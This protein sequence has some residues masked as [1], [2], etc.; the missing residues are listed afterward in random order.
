LQQGDWRASRIREDLKGIRAVVLNEPIHMTH[1]ASPLRRLICSATAF[2]LAAAIALPAFAQ[3]K[4]ETAVFAG[5]CFWTM[6]HGLETI[7]GVVKAVSGYSGGHLKNPRYEDVV[8]ETTG[9]LESVQVTYDPSKISYRQ[10]V[11]RY[12]RLIDPTDDGGQACDRGPSYH[13]AIFVA[14]P[15]Q[16]A[17]AQASVATINT[18]KLKGRIVTPI[19]AAATFYPAEDYH[20]QF[21]IKNPLRYNAYRVGCGRD[22]VLKRIWGG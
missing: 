19:R 18:G 3:A 8:T 1:S 12:W 22:G 9:H 17:A 6:E 4:L 7:P 15:Q 14:S 2:S 10:L 11:D 21:T 13:S 16:L 20:Q 5:G